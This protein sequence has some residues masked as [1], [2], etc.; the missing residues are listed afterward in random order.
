MR[1]EVRSTIATS[2]VQSREMK[3]NFKNKRPVVS[4]LHYSTSRDKVDNE[5]IEPEAYSVSPNK[6]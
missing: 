2:Y 6:N 1:Y 5:D 3:N 4:E